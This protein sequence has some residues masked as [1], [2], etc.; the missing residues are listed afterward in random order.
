VTA[1]CGFG[2]LPIWRFGDLAIGDLAF[3]RFG[4]C[5]FGDCRFGD[6][7]IWRFGTPDDNWQS[8][9]S[10]RQSTI[11]IVSLNRQSQ[12]SVSIDNLNRQPSFSIANRHSQSPTVILN[13]QPSFSIANQ[14]SKKP[15]SPIASP[16][17]I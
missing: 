8:S 9:T 11:P 17:S 6:L 2:V 4:V 3:C 5:R 1:D 13:R 14:Q 10:P 16:Q 7:L 12:S 15:Q